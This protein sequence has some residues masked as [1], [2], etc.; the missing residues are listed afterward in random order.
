MVSPDPFQES[1][2]GYIY[3]IFT[4]LCASGAT[5]KALF[6]WHTG[7][8][9][10]EMNHPVKVFFGRAREGVSFSK[11]TPSRKFFPRPAPSKMDFQFFDQRSAGAVD[12]P[13][14]LFLR[15]LQRLADG[16]LLGAMAF[17][18]AAADAIGGRRGI[19]P[20]RGAHKIF[21]QSP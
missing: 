7:R 14:Q 9:K 6:H 12:R 19:F 10:K 15:L 4:Q 13:F 17:A 16:Q 8:D 3:L 1:R 11:E 18:F 21:R 20:Q 5:I 2:T